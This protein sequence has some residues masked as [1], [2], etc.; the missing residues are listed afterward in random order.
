[1]LQ[2]GPL[3]HATLATE[4]LYLIRD[5]ELIEQFLIGEHARCVKD[6]N[7]SPGSRPRSA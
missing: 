6:R 3:A 7:T 1:M 5:P 2:Y 4:H